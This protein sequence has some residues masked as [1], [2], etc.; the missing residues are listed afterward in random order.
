MLATKVTKE[1]A[2]PSPHLSTNEQGKQMKHNRPV[3]SF[4]PGP[5][6]RIN[7]I[8]NITNINITN[9]NINN[10]N[11]INIY[12]IYNKPG[13]RDQLVTV[14]TQFPSKFVFCAP[15]SKHQ[16]TVCQC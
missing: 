1:T 3:L 16:L 12:N 14:A 7:N 15:L 8:N 9:I 11:D 5:A 13:F 10:I 2:L 4:V 6:A